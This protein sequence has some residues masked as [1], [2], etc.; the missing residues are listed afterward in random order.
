MHTEAPTHHHLTG[1]SRLVAVGLFSMAAAASALAQATTEPADTTTTT[2]TATPTTSQTTT[3]PAPAPSE[4]VVTLSEFTVNGSYAGSL[5]MAAQEKQAA[6]AIVEVL[7]P[8]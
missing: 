4:Q 7:A 8:E 3:A 5:E 6:P 1:R 2:T